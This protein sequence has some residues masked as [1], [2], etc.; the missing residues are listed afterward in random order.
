MLLHT[1]DIELKKSN[2]EVVCIK[3]QEGYCMQIVEMISLSTCIIIN[4]CLIQSKCR[5]PSRNFRLGGN[6]GSLLNSQFVTHL[7]HWLCYE[8]VIGP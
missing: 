3:E 6:W 4:N 8:V 2:K 1:K 5:V 7:W